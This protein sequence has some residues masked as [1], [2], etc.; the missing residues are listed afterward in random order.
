MDWLELIRFMIRNVTNRRTRRMHRTH[1]SG[2]YLEPS[3]IRVKVRDR[4]KV[5]VTSVVV[6]TARVRFRDV[7]PTKHRCSRRRNFILPNK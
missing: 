2:A 5:R 3:A 6:V 4:V 1:A 7:R